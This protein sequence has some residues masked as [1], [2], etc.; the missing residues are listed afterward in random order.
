MKT[1]TVTTYYLEMRTPPE[2]ETPPPLA[3]VE[4]VRV[5]KPP[6]EYYRSLYDAVGKD[7]NWIDRK[8]LSDEGLAQIIHDDR[9]EFYVLEV[10]EKPAGFCELDRRKEGEPPH[11]LEA[12]PNGEISTVVAKQFAFGNKKRI[13]KNESRGDE[14]SETEDSALQKD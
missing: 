11:I 12:P 14:G 9:V 10:G 1:V 6:L 3:G 13:K 2:G 7:W 5:E 4:V 8:R